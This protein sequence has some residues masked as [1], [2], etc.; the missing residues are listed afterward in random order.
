MRVR[1]RRTLLRMRITLWVLG[2]LSVARYM[3]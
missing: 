2:L 1:M 3:I